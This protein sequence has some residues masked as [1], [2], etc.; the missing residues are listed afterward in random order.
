V[1]VDDDVEELDELLELEE[2]VEVELVEVDGSFS[3]QLIL[4][5]KEAMRS[6]SVA[7]SLTFCT[8]PPPV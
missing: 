5:I 6:N 7:V 4:S 1:L 8:L 2:V 3:P